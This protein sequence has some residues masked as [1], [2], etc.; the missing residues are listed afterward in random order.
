[1]RDPY[2]R[3][4]SEFLYWTGT[5]DRKLFD[6][7]KVG[8]D[9]SNCEKFAAH[10]ANNVHDSKIRACYEAG[11][12]EMRAQKKCEEK[13]NSG[14]HSLS[15][16]APQMLMAS[17]AEHLF[18]IEECF[19]AEEGECPLTPWSKRFHGA[20]APVKEENIISFIHHRYHKKIEMV[21]KN[22]WHKDVPKPDLHSCWSR[23]DPELLNLF[24]TVYG[25]DFE[26][27][28]Y[29]IKSSA[30]K[31]GAPAQQ[32]AKEFVG[33][34]L[35]QLAERLP[36]GEHVA[37]NNA[38]RCPPHESVLEDFLHGGDTAHTQ[39]AKA[40]TPPTTTTTSKHDARPKH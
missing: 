20:N 23:F 33:L 12:W 21:V 36:K 31:L 24:N 37:V 25:G 22:A 28:G 38:P 2:E 30:A 40:K 17:R 3:A 11:G 5:Y 14:I 6:S 15:H 16:W 34:T 4:E 18:R 1:V 29:A 8:Y 7:L 9:E 10:L 19:G 26:H 35:G 39:D 32:V 27:L 13:M